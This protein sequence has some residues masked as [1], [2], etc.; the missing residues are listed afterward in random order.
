MIRDQNHAL[1]EVAEEIAICSLEE[2]PT[3]AGVARHPHCCWIEPLC[4][5][6]GQEV[7][8][9]FCEG[10]PSIVPI[11]VDKS[12]RRPQNLRCVDAVQAS[13]ISKYSDRSHRLLLR[14]DP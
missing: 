7:E 3:H 9:L 2:L 5:S 14:K 6:D 4:Q 13:P 8:G 1:W 11:L 12:Q 10:D